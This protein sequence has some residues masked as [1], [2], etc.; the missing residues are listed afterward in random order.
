MKDGLL[1]R[2]VPGDVMVLI[3]RGP[4]GAGMEEI[5]QL[6]GAL[7]YLPFGKHVAIVTDPLTL[8]EPMI[9]TQDFVLRGQNGEGW[10]Y[11]CEAVVEIE[12][13]KGAVPHYLPGENPFHENPYLIAR[14]DQLSRSDDV[15]AHLNRAHFDLVVVD[16]AHRMAAHYFGGEL[17]KLQ[18][19]TPS[20]VDS[21]PGNSMSAARMLRLLLSAA[22]T[23]SCASSL[24]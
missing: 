20:I 13:P 8:T 3:C 6:T 17:K 11:P 2:I 5:Y 7:R 15:L 10:I 24:S 19:R 16:E 18:S 12:R 4:M 9:R 23:L 14:M 1:R 22:I 21:P